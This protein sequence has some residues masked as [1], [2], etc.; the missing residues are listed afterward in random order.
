[1]NKAL[2]TAI[3]AGGCF[4]CMVEP[5]EEH[6]GIL[7]VVMLLIQPMKKFAAA[8]LVIQKQ[9]KLHMTQAK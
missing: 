6:P 9:L 8:K 2:D 4:W 5:F 7:K 3:F 1:M